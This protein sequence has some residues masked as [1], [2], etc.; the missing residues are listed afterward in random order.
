MRNLLQATLCA[1][2]VVGCTTLIAVA[3]SPEAQIKTG[4][5]TV[6]A[7]TTL[8]T[9]LLR[10]Q[11]ITVPQAKSYRTMLAA[12]GESLHEANGELVQCRKDTGSTSATSP[13]PCWPKVSDVVLIALDNIAGVKKALASK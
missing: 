12:A 10:N 11:K 13:D 8:A 3:P 9:V 6:T 4:A 1:A 2:F 5:E 7:T